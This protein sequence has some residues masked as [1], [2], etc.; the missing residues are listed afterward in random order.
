MSTSAKMPFLSEILVD[1]G[2]IPPG[3]LAYFRERF[4]DRLYELV[5]SEFLRREAS[6]QITRAKLAR[7]IG[8]KPEQITRWLGAP[9]NWTLETV[10]DLMLAICKAEPKISLQTL[11][12]RAPRNFRGA[13]WVE[14]P[15]IRLPRKEEPVPQKP[16]ELSGIESAGSNSSPKVL[17][18]VL[19]P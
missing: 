14:P 9:G 2:V 8:R 18:P 19:V 6:G 7:R 11:Q 16:F 17:R 5:V 4:R 3:K 1:D 13:D 15:F 10:S 12:N